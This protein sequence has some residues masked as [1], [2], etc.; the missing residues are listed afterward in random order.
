[1]FT[2]VAHRIL[3]TCNLAKATQDREVRSKTISEDVPVVRL[4]LEQDEA[5]ALLTVL[6]TVGGDPYKTARKHTD[7]VL[8]ALQGAAVQPLPRATVQGS[9]YWGG[10]PPSIFDSYGLGSVSIP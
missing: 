3:R 4:T 2:K 8:K 10:K 1:M 9:L 6:R 5:A 7:R